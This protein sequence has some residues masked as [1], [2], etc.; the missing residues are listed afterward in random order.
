QLGTEGKSRAALF[1]RLQGVRLRLPPLRERLDDLP[2]L[3]GH[4]LDR[5]ARGMSRAAAPG[6]PEA[7]PSLWPFPWAGNARDLQHVL[8]GAMV[9]SDGLIPPAP[10][11]PATQRP[12]AHPPAEA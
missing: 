3:I 12:P 9:M 7:L 10:P 8:G 2:E 6:S 1:Y 5:T 4:L 11:P